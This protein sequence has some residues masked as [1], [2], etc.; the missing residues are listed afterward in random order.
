MTPHV[1]TMKIETDCE[2]ASLAT[3]SGE[4]YEAAKRAIGKT[5]M[6]PES[7]TDPLFGNPENMRNAI[8]RLGY[9]PIRRTQTDIL[10]GEATPGRTVV[11]LVA[12]TLAQHWVVF[13]AINDTLIW[14]HWGDGT[15]RAFTHKQFRDLFGPTDGLKFK[16]NAAFE[17]GEKQ[18]GKKRWYQVWLDRFKNLFRKR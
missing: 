14:F 8:E 6:L 4:S 5:T 11:L 10:M 12:G 1:V 17:V 7:V 15:Q 13:S 18:S 3:A 9:K 16:F 2:E